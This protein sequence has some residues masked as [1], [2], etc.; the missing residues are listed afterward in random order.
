MK[1]LEDESFWN[2]HLRLGSAQLKRHTTHFLQQEELLSVS[3]PKVLVLQPTTAEQ[4]LSQLG[5]SL[6]DLTSCQQQG[7]GISSPAVMGPAL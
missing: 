3:P 1:S 6:S 5:L 4:G 7:T 2:R